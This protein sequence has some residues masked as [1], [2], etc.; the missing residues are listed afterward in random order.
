MA[1]AAAGQPARV[2]VPIEA[3]KVDCKKRG[4][5]SWCSTARYATQ[6]ERDGTIVAILRPPIPGEVFLCMGGRHIDSAQEV[7]ISERARKSLG[8][9]AVTLEPRNTMARYEYYVI[10]EGSGL[11]EPEWMAN[12]PVGRGPDM[13][14]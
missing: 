9:K 14:R 12:C 13:E 5:P 7:R 10:P 2:F 6:G 4:A 11:T 3:E 1:Q 8:A